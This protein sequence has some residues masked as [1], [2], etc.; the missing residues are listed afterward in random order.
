[1]QALFWT[2]LDTLTAGNTETMLEEQLI[3]ISLSA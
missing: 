3:D 1:M 2:N